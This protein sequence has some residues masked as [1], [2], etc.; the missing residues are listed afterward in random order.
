MQL[1]RE[2]KIHVCCVQKC[3]VLCKYDIRFLG[4][5]IVQNKEL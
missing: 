3:C 5:N 2:R 4:E 1:I